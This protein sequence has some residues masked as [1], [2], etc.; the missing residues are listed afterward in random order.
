[1]GGDFDVARPR[2]VQAG[3]ASDEL[4]HLR[5]GLVDGFNPRHPHDRPITFFFFFFF[6]CDDNILH[7][8]NNRTTIDK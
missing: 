7:N 3:P 5:R 4:D 8:I 6:K 1:M 2:L